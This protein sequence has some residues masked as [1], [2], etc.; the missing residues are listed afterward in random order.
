MYMRSFGKVCLRVMSE[1]RRAT[2]ALVPG[3]AIA[4]FLQ[5]TALAAASEALLARDIEMAGDAT[6]TR[7]VVRFNADPEVRWI[8]LRGPH[9][10]VVEF[11]QARFAFEARDMKPRGL[12]RRVSYG[13][14]GEDQS[15]IVLATK[16]PFVIDR[17]DVVAEEN[18]D[19]H[20]L[21]LDIVAAGERAFEAALAEQAETTASTVAASKG[22]RL[23]P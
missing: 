21:V 19:G 5:L 12:V 15:R 22:P 1:V 20:R 10:L 6:R 17:V 4:L 8:L 23:R 3:L 16:G 7:V 14:V 11:P 18:G 2:C 13:R 9:R